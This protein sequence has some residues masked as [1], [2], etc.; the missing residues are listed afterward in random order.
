MFADF[1]LTGIW[2]YVPSNSGDD[3]FSWHNFHHFLSNNFIWKINGKIRERWTLSKIDW[4]FCVAIFN[5]MR[6]SYSYLGAVYCVFVSPLW[7]G[8]SSIARIQACVIIGNGRR[9]PFTYAK[10]YRGQMNLLSE[11][12]SQIYKMRNT[13][14]RSEKNTLFGWRLNGRTC[15]RNV[16]EEKKVKTCVFELSFVKFLHGISSKEIKVIW[17]SSTI[18]TKEKKN[19]FSWINARLMEVA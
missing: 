11:I 1:D 6:W 3:I 7:R 12:G 17:A 15:N 18:L 19:N 5:S 13:K 14:T 4:F 16:V 10:P 8:T 2:A 9:S